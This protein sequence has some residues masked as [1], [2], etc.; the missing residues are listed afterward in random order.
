MDGV[1]MVVTDRYF[2]RCTVSVPKQIK[3][4]ELKTSI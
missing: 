4:N 1:G 3:K 2:R